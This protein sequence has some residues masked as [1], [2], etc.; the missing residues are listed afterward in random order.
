VRVLEIPTP[1]FTTYDAVR[2]N[3][4]LLKDVPATI[5]ERAWSSPI[6]YTPPVGK[7]GA[8]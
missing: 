4:E 7:L 1:R 8:K 3:L 2:N 5:Q 6:W